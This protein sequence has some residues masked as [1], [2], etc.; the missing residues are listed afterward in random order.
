MSERTFVGGIHPGYFK[1]YSSGKPIT[2]AR[3]P[4][5]VI[6]SLHQNI[7]APCDPVVQVGDEVK[8]GQKIGEPKGFVSA[9]IFASVSGKVTKIEPFNHPLGNPVLAVFIENDGQDTPDEGMKPGKTLEELSAEEIKKIAKDAGLVGL[10]GATF[11]THVK[12]SPPPEIKID[13]VIINGAECEPFLTADH[14]QMLEQSDDIVYGLKAFMKALGATKGIIGIEDNKFDAVESMKKAVAEGKGDYD[15]EVHTLHTKYPQGAEKMLIKATTGR[16]VPPGALPMAVNVVNQ[17]SGTAVA[18]AEAIK[19]GK[20][21]YE[22]VVTITGPGIK[23]P[24][25]LLVR[26][27]T[28]VKDLIEQCGGMTDDA[29]KLILGGP[30]MGLAQPTDEV[31]ALKGTSG[32]LVLTEE[33]VKDLPISPCI[34]CGKCLDVCPMSLMPNFIGSASE[35]NM[36]D[37]AEKYGAMDCF[38]CG[39]CTYTCPA[40]RPLVQWIRIAKG[41]IGARRKK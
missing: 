28:L 11:P 17:N 23:E 25:N 18:L 5:Q 14:R 10:G 19:L 9:P 38:E 35:K 39:C 13:T 12:L 3:A 33:F 1:D 37:L 22:R 26:N 21:L 29:R 8:M 32:V 36:I 20:P 7:G 31:P 34:K 24:A 4:A 41:E 15:I 27:G 6:I 30:M 2:S 40:K 16:E